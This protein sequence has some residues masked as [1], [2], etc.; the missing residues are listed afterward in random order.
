MARSIGA[1]SHQTGNFS[2]RLACDAADAARRSAA[3]RAP[4]ARPARTARWCT[5]RF[6]GQGCS[7]A[8]QVLFFERAESVSDRRER[9]YDTIEQPCISGDCG[10]A[11]LV[12]RP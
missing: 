6:I 5:A 4:P 3:G 9:T 10:W 1:G 2:R 11:G 7:I 8:A 12:P